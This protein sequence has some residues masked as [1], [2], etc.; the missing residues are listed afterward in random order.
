M[1][2]L[3]RKASWFMKS[4]KHKEENPGKSN[5]RHKTELNKPQEDPS[6]TLR[7]PSGALH[8]QVG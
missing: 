6:A 2:K 8:W 5:R 3:T 1:K 4:K 7:T